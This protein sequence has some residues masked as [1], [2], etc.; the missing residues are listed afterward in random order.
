MNP[1]QLL[2]PLVTLA[3]ASSALASGSAPT[4]PPRPPRDGAPTETM[5]NARYALGKSVFTG[6][7]PQQSNPAA[8][9]QQRA[10]LSQL[11]AKT[12]EDG[13]SL[14]RLAGKL[15]P[16]QLDALEY[17]VSKRYGAN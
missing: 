15:S 4:R 12:G 3:L 8:A 9:R 17:Y 16:Q 11:A 14:P 10:R 1:T 5:D 13:A 7:A 6:K 2:I